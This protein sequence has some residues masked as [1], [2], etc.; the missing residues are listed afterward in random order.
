MLEWDTAVYKGGDNGSYHAAQSQ[1][2][3]RMATLLAAARQPRSPIP[4]RVKW[5]ALLAQQI[6]AFVAEQGAGD[7]RERENRGP[8]DI[9]ASMMLTAS[10]PSLGDILN[11]LERCWHIELAPALSQI[12]PPI[13]AYEALMP[14]QQLQL[15]RTFTRHILRLLTPLAIDAAHPFPYISHFSLNLAVV[16]HD[17]DNYERY[18]RVKV[19]RLFPRLLPLTWNG[20]LNNDAEP[21]DAATPDTPR[22]WI[23]EVVAANL[24]QLFPALPVVLSAPF[25]VIRQAQEADSGIGSPRGG[26]VVRLELTHACPD[27]LRTRLTKHLGVASDQVH[28]SHGP[29]GLADILELTRF[30]KRWQPS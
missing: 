13:I 20:H 30:P 26:P 22:V 11:Q 12:G 1:W 6:D 2:L 5:L 29:L 9:L 27:V 24:D 14:R 17:S 21:H 15:R 18:A 23:E 16:L 10:P 8:E 7:G 19:P 4:D 28:V 3:N 25:R